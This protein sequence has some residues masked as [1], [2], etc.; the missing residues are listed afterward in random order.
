MLR[1]R[2]E[3]V[4]VGLWLLCFGCGRLGERFPPVD[5]PDG[6]GFS[7]ILPPSPKDVVI[8]MQRQGAVCLGEV[9][10]GL[11]WEKALNG[12]LQRVAKGQPVLSESTADLQPERPDRCVRPDV[13]LRID[14]TVPFARLDPVLTVCTGA[15][16]E[17]IGLQMKLTRHAPRSQFNSAN[18][19]KC[20]PGIVVH[21]FS[22]KRLAGVGSRH[23]ICMRVKADGKVFLNR[24]EL[25]LRELDHWFQAI[26]PYRGDK[27]LFVI[28][29]A[30]ASYDQ[31]VMALAVAEQSARRV[32]MD[33]TLVNLAQAKGCFHEPPHPDLDFE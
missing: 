30:A 12:A 4:F 9:E 32:R 15:D 33:I 14:R 3:A 26:Y 7:E 21:L 13:Y 6:Q 18:H 16:V 28:A 8:S 31:L 11:S 1:I 23:P 25:P 27:S 2:P 24:L 10:L 20:L 5:L 17:L 22:P 19:T 29:D